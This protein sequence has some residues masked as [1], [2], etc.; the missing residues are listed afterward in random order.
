MR[1]K[2]FTLIFL[3][4]CLLPWVFKIGIYHTESGHLSFHGWYMLTFLVVA[5]CFIHELIHYYS[6]EE[7]KELDSANHGG[8]KS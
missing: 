6:H 7:H 5:F 8:K 1:L 2:L 3:G 4:Y